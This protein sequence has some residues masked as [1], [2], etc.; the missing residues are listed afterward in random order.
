MGIS[1]GRP[2]MTGPMRLAPSLRSPRQVDH[3]LQLLL[4]LV[5]AEPCGGLPF[6]VFAATTMADLSHAANTSSGKLTHHF[7]TKGSLFEAIYE[8]LMTHF[9]SG[10]LATLAD[11]SLPPRDRIHG[12]LNG[13]YLLYAMLQDPI[14]CP[15]GHAAGD[16]DGVSAAMKEKAFKLLQRITSFL[17]RHS[18]IWE[19]LL[20]SHWRRQ[21]SLSIRG[22]GP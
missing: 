5:V 18:V 20:R 15:I 12:F 11:T 1:T 6:E 14:G 9:E 21:I 17:K 2:A 22:K 16:S 8:S 19:S 13:I 7:P 10:P 3:A 4:E